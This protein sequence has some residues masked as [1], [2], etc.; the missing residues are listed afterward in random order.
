[1]TR[2]EFV[3][4]NASTWTTFAELLGAL[5]TRA[6]AGPDAAADDPDF[7]PLYRTVCRHL[8]LA[9]RRLYGG[10]LEERLNDL[11]RRG[12]RQLYGA[13]PGTLRGILRFAAFEFPAL[14]RAHAG[15]VAVSLAAFAVPLGLA[16]SLCA[17][18][19]DRLYAVLSADGVAEVQRMYDPD[20][21]HF[22]RERP[23]SGD[24]QMFGFY[25][26]NNVGV[27]FRVFAGGVLAGVG[28]LAFLVMNGG[29]IG[30]VAGHLQGIGYGATF[31][32]FAAGHG[33]FELTAIVLAGAA[34]LGMGRA[35]VAPGRLGRVPA[36]LAAAREGVRLLYGCA[37]MLVVAAF[38]EAYW[39]PKATVPPEAKF[40]VAAVLWTGVTAWLA[41]AG[42]GRE[43]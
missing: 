10:D 5:E 16:W 19:P 13:R 17:S 3:R 7:A 18:D 25:V 36:L 39:S 34:G 38:V 21:A 32:P 26:M 42:R 15:A 31:F 43:T 1:M 33:A 11:A 29:S 14:V 2:E 23:G 28:T 40:A 6:P 4:R 30:A 9:R 8:A 12:H 41:F 22:G 20:S 24:L 37:G 27:A 35:I